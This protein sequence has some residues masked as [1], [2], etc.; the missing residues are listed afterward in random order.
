M[1]TATKRAARQVAVRLAAWQEE[2]AAEQA[3]CSGALS[4]FKVWFQAGEERDGGEGLYI[5]FHIVR[6][7]NPVEARCRVESH[8]RQNARD[9]GSRAFCAPEHI[10]AISVDILPDHAHG[11][12]DG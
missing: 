10:H 12:V 4:W 7:H 9:L 5:D 1:T 6:A 3:R 11:Q 8:E 2:D